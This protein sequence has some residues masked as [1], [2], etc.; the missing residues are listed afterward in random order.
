MHSE[1]YRYNTRV[2]EP[3]P[4]GDRSRGNAKERAGESDS[5][6][7]TGIER[8]ETQTAQQKHNSAVSR[9]PRTPGKNSQKVEKKKKHKK[10]KIPKGKFALSGPLKFLRS[11]HE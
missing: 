7:K 5:A 1:R 9:A 2:R 3:V 8:G 6:R 10:S 4:Q 11:N